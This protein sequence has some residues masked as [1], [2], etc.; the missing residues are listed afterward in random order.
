MLSSRNAEPDPQKT[1]VIPNAVRDLRL[2]LIAFHSTTAAYD[3]SMHESEPAPQSDLARVTSG[4]TVILPRGSLLVPEGR[5]IIA[6]GETRGNAPTE[7]QPRP[8]G[9]L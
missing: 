9:A 6:P 1:V 3:H 8:G 7:T 4:L 2:F 5:V